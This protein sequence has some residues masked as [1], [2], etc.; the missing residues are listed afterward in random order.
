MSAALMSLTL[1]TSCAISGRLLAAADTQGKA[2]A[3]VVLP[4]LPTDCRKRE[5]HAFKAGDEAMTALKKE[6]GALDRANRRVGRC[7][8]FYDDVKSGLESDDR[9]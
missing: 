7:A 6:R 4:D 3:R 1:T 5:A 9:P 8:G 2:N